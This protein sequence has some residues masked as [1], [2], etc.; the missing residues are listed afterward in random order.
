[1]GSAG[2]R[3]PL[4]GALLCTDGD[5]IPLPDWAAWFSELGAWAVE[6][7][8]EGISG[9]IAVS[10]PAREYASVLLG[11]GA[12]Y[13]AF[14][15]Q[16]DVTP[17]GSQFNRAAKLVPKSHVVRLIPTRKT[18]GFVGILNEVANKHNRESYNVS[19]GWFPADRY[20][21]DVLRWPDSPRNFM[22]QSR[23]LEQIDIPNGA[24]GLLP[25]AATDFCGFSALHC[26]IVGNCRTIQQESE[27]LIAVSTAA[28]PLPLHALLRPRT[29][30]DKARQFRSVLLSARED[31]EDYRELVTE[32]KPKVTILDGAAT[33]CRWLGAG[34][35][36]ITVALVERAAPS[37]EA[38]ADVLDRYR[39]RSLRD[40]P[41]LGDL[42]SVPAGIEV[43]AW[44][45]RA[46]NP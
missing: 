43:L 6:L 15:P 35:A 20:R 8:A 33:V 10:A 14:Q 41:L 46:G 27:T 28:E 16:L 31:P 42:A 32:R 17:E 3:T 24:D 4:S 2:G 7:A 26:A 22:G 45:S 12:V 19:G 5:R 23:I 38:A 9:T 25:G 13:A 18:T 37:S 39:A 36:P 21:I 30:H 29:V 1:V 40:L 34:M 11:C 44:Q